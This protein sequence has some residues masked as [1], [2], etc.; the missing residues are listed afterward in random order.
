MIIY[1][2]WKV[3][4]LLA[5]PVSN[6]LRQF[7]KNILTKF[8]PKVGNVLSE[9]YEHLQGIINGSIHNP[10]TGDASCRKIDDGN[11]NHS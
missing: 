7:L 5:S 10:K 9:I 3:E 1:L 6:S 11:P 8:D 4:H 2:L